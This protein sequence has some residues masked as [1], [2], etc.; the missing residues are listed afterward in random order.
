MLIFIFLS[1]S[2]ELL[3]KEQHKSFQEK[4]KL[5]P[6]GRK[7]EFDITE[8]LEDSKDEKRLPNKSHKANEPVVLPVPD[9]D[10]QKLSLP[11]QA[12]ASR[13]LVPPGFR[14]TIL[15]KNFVAKTLSDSRS[16]EVIISCLYLI[17]SCQEI[18][19]VLASLLWK[20]FYLHL[21]QLHL[22]LSCLYDT[23][24]CHYEAL[25]GLLHVNCLE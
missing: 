15:E 24:L 6:E 10:S 18:I 19:L 20:A 5:N 22:L 14:S 9:N 23:I 25:L 21:L 11:S 17:F 7:N 16:S 8:L 13:P 2:F 3:R 1:A 12:P 4:Q